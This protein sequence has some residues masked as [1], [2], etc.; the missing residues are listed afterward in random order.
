M[1]VYSL[2]ETAFLF[3]ASNY[4]AFLFCARNYF[5]TLCLKLPYIPIPN[6]SRNGTTFFLFETPSNFVL[7]TITSY[8]C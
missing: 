1:Y 5:P 6:Y 4:P 2:L 3:C 7:E 8:M